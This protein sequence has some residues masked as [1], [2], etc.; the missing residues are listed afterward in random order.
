MEG[1]YYAKV[2]RIK[3]KDVFNTE[4]MCQGMSNKEETWQS[5]FG[6]RTWKLN[7]ITQYRRNLEGGISSLV[8]LKKLF[9]RNFQPQQN[10][11]G[12]L[13]IEP[14][15]IMNILSSSASEHVEHNL[16]SFF[17]G[18]N[19]LQMIFVPWSTKHLRGGHI[20][21]ICDFPL[22]VSKGTN[23]KGWKHFVKWNSLS[24]LSRKRISENRC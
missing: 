19:S 24:Q 10:I 20:T 9:S 15:K 3:G 14:P 8:F 6:L 7:G 1:W 12:T 23:G 2:C 18:Q 11:R 4:A 22:I 21:Y 5:L 13:T 17:S 16:N